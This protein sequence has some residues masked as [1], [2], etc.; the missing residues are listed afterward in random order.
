MSYKTICDKIEGHGEGIHAFGQSSFLLLV[1]DNRD[2]I[3]R[4]VST[5]WLIAKKNGND[6]LSEIVKP[7]LKTGLLH[8]QRTAR[9]ASDFQSDYLDISGDSADSPSAATLSALR[10]GGL[11][12]LGQ[13]KAETYQSFA[14]AGKSIG[15]F[16][17]TSSCRYFILS[18]KG[19]LGGHSVA[20]FR[21]WAFFGKSSSCVFF[22]PNFGEFKLEGS[23]GVTRCLDAV[24]ASYNQGL[25]KGYRIWGFS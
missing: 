17:L 5:A 20:F 6:Y 24:A 1:A 7:T 18:I 13:K 4:G 11:G 3:C 25:S 16:V 21:P 10:T 9:Q 22:D 15:E 23:E 12:T 2:G 8:E 19:T 14:T